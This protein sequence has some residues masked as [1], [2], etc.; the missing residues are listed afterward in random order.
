MNKAYKF[1]LY[2]TAEQKIAFAKTFGCVRFIYN[3][4]LA[5]KI[6]YYNQTGKMLVTTPAAYKKEYEWLKE[7]DSL[8]LAN[9]QLQLQTAYQNFF[10]DKSIG[11]PKFHNKKSGKNSYTTNNQKGSIRIEGNQIKL[12]KI[13]WVKVKFHRPIP[14]DCD[15]KSA[16]ISMTATGKYFVSVLTELFCVVPEKIL[17]PENS[18]GLDYSSPHFYVD[19]LG[20]FAD[21]PHFY[22][23]TEQR[24]AKEQRR[25]SKMKKGSS[26]YSKQKKRVAKI[27]EKMKNQRY[28]WQH[29][30]S[31]RLA[32]Q[33][34]VVC[35]EDI[36]YKG[37]AQGL[38][39]AK[40]TNDNAFG[41]FR[42]LLSYKLAE[43]GKKLITINKW[44][45]SSKTCRH[46]G[47]VNADLSVSDRH[48]ICPS[49][50]SSIDRDVNAA[51]NIRNEG[52]ASLA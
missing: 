42:K 11:F 18:I 22:R 40:A 35:V 10:R 33:Y 19:S 27:H 52:I 24:L 26:N 31:H 38:R 45:P 14:D 43:Q 32:D 15:I 3:K 2:P 47:Y 51:L 9:A 48:W 46:C 16:T 50:G 8:A 49:C 41:Q 29:K 44:F 1:R 36:N 37:M 34:D 28:D 20:N 23:A 13:G 5:D 7:V 21:M 6:D 17:N 12:P 25:L 30:E 4:M 39:L